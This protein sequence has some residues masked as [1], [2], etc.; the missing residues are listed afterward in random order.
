MKILQKLG[1]KVTHYKNHIKSQLE[2]I[3]DSSEREFGDVHLGESANYDDA[4]RVFLN[5]DT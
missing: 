3:L 5:R 1:N 2:R 4:A